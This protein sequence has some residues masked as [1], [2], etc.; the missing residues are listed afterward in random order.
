MKL[1]I[2]IATIPS[3][4]DMLNKL[5]TELIRQQSKYG[6]LVEILGC[7]DDKSIGAKRNELLQSS[8]GEYVCFID[9]DDWVSSTYIDD[10]FDAIKTDPDCVSLRGVITWDG[11]SP[12]IFEH[13]LKYKHYITHTMPVDGIKY[14]RYPNHLN[15]IKSS[16]AKQFKFPEI[17][18]GEDKAWADLI[19]ES[20]LLKKEIYIDKI[21]YHYI[22]IT[23]K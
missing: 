14:E 16:I 11:A 20:G 10:I 1:S 4:A 22:Y 8:S 19:N 13:S 17:N 5:V 3:R 9:D 21:L 7:S 18:H 2:L 12:E 23:N 15:T 6:D